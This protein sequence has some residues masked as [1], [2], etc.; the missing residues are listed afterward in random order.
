MDTRDFILKY[1]QRCEMTLYLLPDLPDEGP[2]ITGTAPRY[3]QGDVISANCSSA[4]S[5][6]AAVLHWYI[7]GEEATPA[8]LVHYPVLDVGG[9]RR[10]SVLG[11]R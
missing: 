8:M 10:T 5:L 7:N 4:R 9:G 3:K 2:V 6:P 1:H 11:L